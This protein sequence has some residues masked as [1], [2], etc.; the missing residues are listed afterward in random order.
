MAVWPGWLA[1]AARMTGYP[2]VEVGGWRT[3]GHGG[4]RVVE[5]VVAH[6]TA[7]GPT[8]DYPSLRIVRDGR[9]GLSGPLSQLGLGRR[10][11]IYVIAAGQSWHAGASSWAGFWDLNDEAIGIEAESVG[12]RDDWTPEQRDCYPRLCAALL[13]FM[14][15]RA[16][17]CG[18]HKEVCRPAGRKIDPAYWHMPGMRGEIQ[19]YLD[20]PPSINRHWQHEEDDMFTDADRALLKR[21]H[22]EATLFLL[23]RRAPGQDKERDTVLGF[24][25]SAEGRSARIE[26][27]TLRNGELL[28]GIVAALAERE[29]IDPAVITQAVK[30]GATAA[31]TDTVLPELQTVVREVLGADNE[32]QAEAIVDA[33][34]ERLHGGEAAPLA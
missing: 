2:V 17:R 34:A 21:V 29:G 32:A 11:T 7:D 4:M 9:A 1:D 19:R 10:G 3:R 25:A 27:Y 6:H 15:R 13:H 18:A 20:N 33:L 30:I 12:T 14:R 16:D 5:V 31:I 22:H 24:A 23:N 8:G 28:D 26:R